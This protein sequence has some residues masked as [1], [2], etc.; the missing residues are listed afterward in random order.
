MNTRRSFL[1]A[2][3]LALAGL[4][5]PAM[6]RAARPAEVRMLSTP[7]G[8][9]A[10]FDPI[11]L[12]IEPGQTVRWVMASPGNPHT[13]TAYHP[14]NANHSL[15]IPQS[16]APWDSGFLV[17]PGATFEVTLTVEGVYDYFCLPHEAA[18]MVGRIVVGRPGGPGALPFDYFTS[19][20][21]TSA[22]IPVAESARAAFPSVAAI[23]AAGAV[24]R[25]RVKE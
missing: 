3:G 6:L 17:K 19:H 2:G 10:W 11:G 24:R 16:A 15:R 7:R 5:V 9:E 8:E 23:V 18:G 25:P 22:W 20:A 4:A 1:T 21:G 13:T 12:R 14:R